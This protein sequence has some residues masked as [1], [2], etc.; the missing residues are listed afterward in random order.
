MLVYMMVIVN[1]IMIINKCGLAGL[2]SLSKQIQTQGVQ[3]PVQM[4]T[5]TLPSKKSRGGRSHDIDQAGISRSIE[6][7]LQAMHVVG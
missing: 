3:I 1:I 6:G 4:P 7:C 2:H 5:E